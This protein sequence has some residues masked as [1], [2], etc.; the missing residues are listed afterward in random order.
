MKNARVPKPYTPYYG[1]SE[2]ED[3]KVVDIIDPSQDKNKNKD[4]D[5]DD[6]NEL[7]ELEE[8]GMEAINNDARD[9][10]DE[11]VKRYQNDK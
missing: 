11:G 1:D 9:L 4:H 10:F 5:D 2:D 7:D 6:G 8:L 3:Y